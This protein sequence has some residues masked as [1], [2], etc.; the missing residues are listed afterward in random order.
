MKVHI[1]GKSV[2]IACR[3]IEL[4]RLK[5]QIVQRLGAEVSSGT[6][7]IRVPL[8]S[9]PILVDLIDLAERDLAVNAELEKFRHHESARLKA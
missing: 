1:D 3:G 2:H 5:S 4:L 8:Y 6:D 9:L 7:H